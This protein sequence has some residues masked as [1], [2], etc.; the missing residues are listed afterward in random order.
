MTVRWSMSAPDELW[1]PHPPEGVAERLRAAVRP[2][3]PL[4]GLVEADRFEV[5]VA[6]RGRRNGWHPVMS[7]RLEPHEGGTRMRL[8]VRPRRWM[9][10]LSA[11]YSLPLFGV[12]WLIG[13][14]A[15]SREVPGALVALAEVTDAVRLDGPPLLPG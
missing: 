2:D 5:K 8:E 7:G 13:A 12:V 4:A 9:V 3:G 10:V 6:I 14:V 15:F 1:S 11:V